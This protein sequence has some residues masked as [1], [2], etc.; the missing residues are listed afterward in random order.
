[1]AVADVS[2]D[3]APGEHGEDAEQEHELGEGDQSSIVVTS[4]GH[5]ARRDVDRD[6]DDWSRMRT[7]SSLSQPGCAG[8]SAKRPRDPIAYAR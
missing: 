6:D 7:R 8:R 3:D 4:A 1:V 2:H 5:A